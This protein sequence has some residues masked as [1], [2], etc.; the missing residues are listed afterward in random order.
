ML[1]GDPAEGDGEEAQRR[2]KHAQAQEPLRVVE[3]L[4]P[5]QPERDQADTDHQETDADHEAEGPEDD[6]RVRPLV[7]R[8]GL[9]AL[10]LGVPA[11]AQ[12]QAAE[13]RDPDGVAGGLGLEVGQAEE[14]ER[15]PGM[16]LEMALH[17]GDLGRLVLQRVEAVE[18]AGYRLQRGHQG[19]HPHRHREHALGSTVPVAL[20][21]V[22]RTHAADHEGRGQVGAQHG[23]DEAVGK[24][25]I[26]DDLPP[27]GG[28]EAALDDGVAGRRVHPAVGREDPEGGEEGA[29][30]HHAGGEEVRLLADSLPAEEH[31]PQEAGL[32]EEGGQHLVGHDRAHD[33]TH[34]VAHP[35]PVGAELVGHD[36]SGDDAHAEGD[37]E[38]RQ[39]ELVELAVDR[40]AGGEPEALQHGK[41]AGEPD[42]EG[43][44]QEVEGDDEG[45]LEARQHDRIQPLHY[46]CPSGRRRRLACL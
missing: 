4:V 8:E 26:E 36:D 11:V 35:A 42:G 44:E 41:V 25:G 2:G 22:P 6:G 28:L 13:L 37:G 31:D 20:E 1:G 14:I 24:G 39:P 27:V 29:Q 15:R 7:A 34:G 18:V 23:V 46:R 43:R 40:V 12:D 3:P 5:A 19:R 38:D 32:E 45:E 16:G 33:G 9:Q 17:G 30:R 10:E 21:Q